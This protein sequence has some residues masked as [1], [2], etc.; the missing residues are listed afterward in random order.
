MPGHSHRVAPEADIEQA[1]DLLAQAGYPGGK[2]LPELEFWIPFW[3]DPAPFVE[4]WGRLGARFRVTVRD[5]EC[6]PKSGVPTTAHLWVAGWHADYPDPDGFFR[7]LLQMEFG[8]HRDE[9]LA[10]MVAEARS[11]RNQAERMRRYNEID[12][13]LVAEQAAILP[14][15]Y[16]RHLV[17]RRPWIENLW[18][19]PM[20]GVHLDQVVTQRDRRR[21]S[22][23]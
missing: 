8:F 18:A 1:R 22:Q 10:E 3:L 11:L 5:P 19:N 16:G 20:S 9:G 2:G 13:I 6:L 15:L 4:Q 7:G 17:V 23:P 12:R 14:L 21:R